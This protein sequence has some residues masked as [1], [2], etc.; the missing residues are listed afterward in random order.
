MKIVAQIEIPNR[1]FEMGY[2]KT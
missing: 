2:N 1:P